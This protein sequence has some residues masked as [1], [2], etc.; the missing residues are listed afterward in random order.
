MDAM[1][2]VGYQETATYS[3][4]EKIIYS[5]SLI[6]VSLVPIWD[7]ESS[8]NYCGKH[9]IMYVSQI[10]IL[11]TLNL[12]TVCVCV[13]TCVQLFA[14]PCTVAHQAPLSMEFSRQGYWSGLPFPPPGDLPDLGIELASFAS[15]ALTGGFFTISTTWETLRYNAVYQLLCFP[16]GTSGKEHAYQCRRHKK[17]RFDPWVKDKQE[18]SPGEGHGNPFQY[19]CLENPIGQRSLAGCSP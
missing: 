4:Q 13:F 8:L 15:P 2:T 6:S 14:T 3:S 16:G 5:I 7:D 17:N 10:T 18:R 9:F 11:Y 1:Q 19:S 12:Y